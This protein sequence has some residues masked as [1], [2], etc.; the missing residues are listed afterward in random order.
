M[1]GDGRE[2]ATCSLQVA[3][4]P[5]FTGGSLA[6]SADATLAGVVTATE[7]SCNVTGG[8][9]FSWSTNA[10]NSTSGAPLALSSASPSLALPA[11]S[12]GSG[13]TVGFT[14]AACFAGARSTCGN[15]SLAFAVTASPLVAL[16]GGAG[17]V[18]GE[19][20]IVLSAAAS[21]DPDG[22]P[23]SALAF[24]WACAA[25]DGAA[26]A[27]RDGTP[28]V[29][30][31][32]A[33]QSAQLR[34]DA[35]GAL[36]TISLVVSLG[37]RSSSTNTTLTVLPGAL[38]LV[39]IA[40]NTVLAGAKAN[41]ALQLV[42]FANATAFVA[43]P[44]ETRWSVAAQSVP[45]PLLNLS[46]PAVCAT[47]VTSISMVLRPGALLPGARYTFSLRATDAVGATGMANAT[48]VTS[49]PARGGWAEALPAAGV[50]LSTPFVLTASGWTADA[51]ELPLSY[52]LDY[53]VEGSADGPVSLTSGAFQDSPVIRAQLPAGLPANDNLITL[54]L[55]VRSAFGATVTSNASVAV[56]WPIFEDAAAVASFVGGATERA[57]AALQ[58]GDASAAMQVVG[59]LAA[60]LNGD[61]SSGNDAAV[62]DQ[63]ASLLSI[64]A[65]ALGQS[66]TVI[67]PAAVESTAALVSALV[68]SPAQ[69]SG[70]GALSALSVLGSVAS[71]GAAVSPAAAQSV[72]SAL[73][74]VALAPAGP[75]GEGGAATSNNFAAVLGVLDSLASSQ[76][77]GMSVPGQEAATV[78]TPVIQMAVS[79]DEPGSPRLFA[80]PLSAPGS[81]SSFDPLPPGALASAGGAPVS[82]L[83]MALAF[84][85][86]GGAGSSNTAGITR[87]AF[88]SLSGG[89]VAVENLAR[90]ILFTIPTST[91]AS[92]QQSACA[93]WDE[94]AA[95]Y[96]TAG[97]AALP[98]PYPPGHALR[99]ATSFE[100][101]GPA[102]LSAA[103][104]VSGPLLAGCSL[105]FL[106]CTNATTRLDV[107]QLAP[108]ASLKC[109]NASDIVLRAYVGAECA[110]RST[111]NASVPCAWDALRQ[112]FV[113]DGCVAAEATRCACT[114]LTDFVSSSKPNLPVASMSDLVGLNPADIVTKLKCAL[115]RGSTRAPAAL[116][117]KLTFATTGCCSRWSSRFLGS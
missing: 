6:R 18:V 31:T 17:G 56:A 69:L 97:C 113:G 76:S 26:C 110:L 104:N 38:P 85:A 59:G 32:G 25:A 48:I 10:A 30:G 36:Y 87:L 12:L 98:S 29:L 41:P 37:A 23:L 55:T 117:A 43:G 60:L 62:A 61:A 100:A 33:T 114:H 46:D 22:A 35:A 78:S 39:S 94:A 45:G 115:R 86:H 42:L 52:L 34:G 2:C 75:S 49:S 13:Q 3:I 90:P 51:D 83:F 4:T 99:F 81:N 65:G 21:R 74:S 89:A 27:A 79:Y 44:V 15:A 63:R 105:V 116:D 80:A 47:P 50:A 19:M 70:A 57:A 11:R 53:F 7:A 54:R 14:L 68:S 77:T 8:F 102:S 9:A 66:G 82:T 72:A 103:W 101:S 84:D 24:A 40:G 112:A 64:V 1:A 5:S 16:I 106:D 71:A 108:G 109:G 67:A 58:S 20:P 28:V 111:G 73:S 93:W 96:S 107:L 88:S 95:T 91:L 92:G